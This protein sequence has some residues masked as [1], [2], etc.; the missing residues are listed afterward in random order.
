[1]YNIG[2]K[3]KNYKFSLQHL[4]YNDGSSGSSYS[5]SNSG[6]YIFTV[7]DKD[8]V[9]NNYSNFKKLDT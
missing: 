3:N 7:K 1:M 8:G 6:L 4:A 2:L 9:P 5:S